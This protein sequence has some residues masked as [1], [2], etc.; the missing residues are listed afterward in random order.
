MATT[1][2]SS[3]RKSPAR[4]NSKAN[5]RSRSAGSLDRLNESLDAAQKAL[6]DLQGDL[7]R[8]AR[9]VAKNV[10][11]LIRDARR[12]TAKLNR[13]LVKDIGQLGQALT[14]GRDGAS[15]GSKKK[16]VK[17]AATKRASAAKRTTPKSPA[18]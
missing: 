8:G 13:A 6:S 10:S 12:D 7:G 16:P 3:A 2:K 11:R 4:G 14:P 5:Q 18:S 1:K 17:R 9:D 15:R